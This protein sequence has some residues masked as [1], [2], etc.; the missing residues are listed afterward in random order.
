MF[1]KYGRILDSR[2]FA[3]LLEVVCNLFRPILANDTI[4]AIFASL[5]KAILPKTARSNISIVAR[6][7]LG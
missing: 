4:P 6:K 7:S 5:G 2:W 3:M 1:K